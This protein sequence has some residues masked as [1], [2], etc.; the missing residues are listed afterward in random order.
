MSVSA[1]T[2]AADS[3]QLRHTVAPPL[4]L[5]PNAP[6]NDMKIS[7]LPAIAGAAG[8][9][10]VIRAAFYTPLEARQGA[11]QKIFY[12]HVPAPWGAFLAFFFL[13]VAGRGYLWI[14]DQRPARFPPGSA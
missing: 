13:A 14:Q 7:W 10:T 12:I 2:P 9:G 3:L 6:L 1:P 4:K 5:S 11:A 8:V